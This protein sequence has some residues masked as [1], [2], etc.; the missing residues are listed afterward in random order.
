MAVS[1]ETLGQELPI[2][3]RLLAAVHEL[4]TEIEVGQMRGCS[5]HAFCAPR[6]SEVRV[7]RM[8]AFALVACL[9]LLFECASARGRHQPLSASIPPDWAKTDPS[10]A[11]ESRTRA[12]AGYSTEW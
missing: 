1:F 8:R 4:Q 11:R 5:N 3:E 12:V 6:C 2:C 9:I 7:A 10:I